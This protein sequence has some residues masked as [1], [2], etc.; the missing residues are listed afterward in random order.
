MLEC[1]RLSSS[2]QPCIHVSKRYL[3]NLYF[4]LLITSIN[5]KGLRNGAFIYI[6]F[7]IFQ[8]MIPQFAL[9]VCVSKVSIALLERPG[10]SEVAANCASSVGPLHE[11]LVQ[12]AT[13]VSAA[14]AASATAGKRVDSAELD[15]AVEAAVASAVASA[16]GGGALDRAVGRAVDR[17]VG[18]A[19]DPS[20][21]RAVGRL[22]SELGERQRQALGELRA[23][24]DD[25]R[26]QGS[27]PVGGGE[28]AFLPDHVG[29]HAGGVGGAEG[30]E[31][32]GYVSPRSGP[33]LARGRR[34]PPQGPTPSQEANA[35]ASTAAAATAASAA[36]AG[37]LDEY[38]SRFQ[39][40]VRGQVRVG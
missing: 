39:A 19:V 38:G 28:R 12:L 11:Q 33:G 22:A 16:L 9:H 34:A 18:K 29:G 17:A 10:R 40:F 13:A 20:V 3:F 26:R 15:A 21:E 1:A 32:S 25:E 14:R 31:G 24:I 2:A 37:V 8:G 4:P 23:S 6:Y 5:Q 27:A 36:A 35:A 30:G 7:F